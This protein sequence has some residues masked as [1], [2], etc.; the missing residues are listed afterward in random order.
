MLFQIAI[1]KSANS[2]QN[3]APVI[4]IALDIDTKLSCS[5]I[6]HMK[7]K[8]TVFENVMG[9]IFQMSLTH[10]KESTR[11][12]ATKLV[13]NVGVSKIKEIFDEIGRAHV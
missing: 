13:E 2:Y 6:S 3:Q 7:M 12:G 4:K 1:E 11:K 10:S 9:L 5:I 8:P